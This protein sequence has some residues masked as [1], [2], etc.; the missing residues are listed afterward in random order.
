MEFDDG[1]DGQVTLGEIDDTERKQ[2][3]GAL[4]G[5]LIRRVAKLDIELK[6][7]GVTVA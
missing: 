6:K 4:R 2:L 3:D 1:E 5:I 7:F